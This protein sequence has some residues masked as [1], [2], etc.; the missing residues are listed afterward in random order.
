MTGKFDKVPVE[1]D[2]AIWYRKEAKVGSYDVLYEIWN[3]DG[4]TGTSIIFANED[5]ED[6]QDEE[7]ENVVRTTF[8]LKE[9]SPM[10]LKRS[11]SGYTFVNFDFEMGEK[12]F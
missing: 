8:S 3:W 7:I 12:Q 1:E 2:T 6:L 11:D 10:T 5:V 9:D 4:I